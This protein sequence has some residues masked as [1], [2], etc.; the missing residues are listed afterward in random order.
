MTSSD[1]TRE[2]PNELQAPAPASASPFNGEGPLRNEGNQL[3]AASDSQE[4]SPRNSGMPNWITSLEEELDKKL[5]VVLRDGRK[6][7]GYLRTFDQFGN[8]VLE[9]TVQRLL[10]DN[11]YADLYV[12]CMIVRGDNMIL[13]GAVDDSRPTPLEPKPLCDVLAAKQE[14]EEQ[15]RQKRVGHRAWLD[16]Q[17]GEDW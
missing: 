13:F 7:I 2:R 10:V 1:S 5:L 3:H 9:G 15:E 11:A 4:G 17:L 8:I 14:Q 16:R 6:L 12:G